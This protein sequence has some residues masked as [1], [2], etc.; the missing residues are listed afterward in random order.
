MLPPKAIPSLLYSKETRN[1]T[2]QLTDVYYQ[3]SD[4]ENAQRAAP[5]PKV[6]PFKEPSYIILKR[7]VN[8]NFMTKL[9]ILCDSRDAKLW[10]LASD[11][12]SPDKPIDLLLI[13]NCFAIHYYF[14]FYQIFF[15]YHIFIAPIY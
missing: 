5:T 12:A 1:R 6:I 8:I 10:T 7:H 3:V 13:L 9:C 2:S 4:M 11:T 14:I 15:R